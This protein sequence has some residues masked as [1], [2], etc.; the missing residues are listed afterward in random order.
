[1][2]LK[3][4]VILKKVP[5]VDSMLHRCGQHKTNCLSNFTCYF[6]LPSVNNAAC[7]VKNYRFVILHSNLGNLFFSFCGLNLQVF[8]KMF[9]MS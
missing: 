5:I 3:N 4:V 2:W 8:I 7:C 9:A 1:M 6:I